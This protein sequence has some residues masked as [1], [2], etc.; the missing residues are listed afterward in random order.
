[1]NPKSPLP[2]TVYNADRELAKKLQDL[3]GRTEYW[4]QKIPDIA[5]LIAQHNL[6][7]REVDAFVAEYRPRFEA[8]VQRLM[9]ASPEWADASEKD[10]QDLREEFETK[11]I[12]SLGVFVGRADLA[13]LL[14]GE[15]TNFTDDDAVLRRLGD[16]SS[17]YPFYISMLGRNV[18]LAT[19][20]ADDYSR[21]VWEQLVEKGFARRGKDIPV[22]Q[23]LNGLRL[24]DINE[25]L[26]GTIKKPFG[27]KAQAIEAA[28]NLPDLAS[29]LSERIAYREMFQVIPPSGLEA[30]ELG[31]SFA[32]ATALASVVQQTYYTG[33]RTVGALG[34]RR[35]E[36]GL[37]DAWEIT[38]WED[39]IP[40]CAA[41]M[42]KKYDRL[43]AKRPPFHIGCVCQL[44]CSFKD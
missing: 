16:S 22:Q 21:K 7:F 29:R 36:S 30:E 44:E 25:L 20:K 37:Y 19:V 38:N 5:L 18:Q 26:A 2:L 13:C 8:E 11:A 43:P 34:E 40:P 12:K 28:L 3:L 15:P 31:K 32:Y 35:R 17:L 6:C 1:L 23:L 9:S 42:C 14:E 27:R 4:S 41:P 33:V 24:K 39:P 10:R